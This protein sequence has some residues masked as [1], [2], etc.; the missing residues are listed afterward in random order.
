MGHPDE[1][2][3]PPPEIPSDGSLSPC[4]CQPDA[5]GDQHSPSNLTTAWP[6]PHRLECAAQPPEAPARPRRF[7]AQPIEV[8]SRSSKAQ[9]TAV[10]NKTDQARQTGPCPPRKFLPNPIETTKSSNR[11]VKSQ[12]DK[13]PASTT[14]AQSGPRRFK[15]E[16]IETDTRSVRRSKS[17]P[18]ARRRD[19]DLPESKFSYANLLNRQEASRHSFRVP[20]L[21][22]IPSNSSEDSD[23]SESPSLATSSSRL[24]H[25][26]TRKQQNEKRHRESCD[27][28]FSEYLLSLAAITAEE[29]LRDQALAAFPNEQVH[30]PVDHFAIDEDE[31]DLE[32]E[33]HTFRPEQI[34]SRR[35]SSADLSWEL[36][37]MRQ[38]KEEAEMRLRAMVASRHAGPKSK[39]LP[40][41]SVGP[42]DGRSEQQ[43]Q[44]ASPPML[45]DDVVIPQS[46][47]PVG[48][49]CENTNGEK[50]TSVSPQDPCAHCGGLWCAAP[51]AE[52]GGTT[53]L[54]MGTCRRG[55]RDVSD[56]HEIGRGV[57]TPAAPSHSPQGNEDWLGSNSPDPCGLQE[58][59][60]PSPRKTTLDEFHDG[61]VTQIYN[62]LSLGYPC[63]ARYYDREL[64]RISG[65]SVER[66]RQ[67]DLQTDAK[68]YVVASTSTSQLSCMR[69]KALRL[70]IH[71]WA[72]QQP[73]ME[74][75]TNVEAWGM[76]ERRGSWAV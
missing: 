69:W 14:P 8:S 41:H 36:E 30:Q 76:R 75:D 47:S 23:D 51:L 71:E 48:S 52:N 29:Q 20:D 64:S 16:V 49:L 32:E 31:R 11:R 59:V 34:K 65:I 67:D 3:P 18:Q 27:D 45:G 22:S 63:L 40:T 55:S 68:G 53:G 56:M 44:I 74:D 54:W 35:Q 60:S 73:S 17:L 58:R 1:S 19:Y 66:L 9:Q 50:N 7:V 6:G 2:R 25:K 46:L 33:E 26:D 38:H 13:E 4:R 21:P 24:S 62:Y 39:A 70:Y 12:Q 72:R 5:S 15:P 57:M 42:L 37:Y 43:K 61:F 10:S 28:A